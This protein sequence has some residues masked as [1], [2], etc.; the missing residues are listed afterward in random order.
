[1]KGEPPQKRGPLV[2]PG[3]LI[4]LLVWLLGAY[5]AVGVSIGDC[6]PTENHVCPTDH[7]RRL[8]LLWIVLATAAL[9]LVLLAVLIVGRAKRR[10]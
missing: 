9:N 7:E 1:M 3:R 10:D 4:S 8:Q 5:V 6:F 2:L